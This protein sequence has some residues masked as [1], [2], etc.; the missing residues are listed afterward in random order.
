MVLFLKNGPNPASFCLFSSFSQHNDKYITKFDFECVDIL[1][2][3][4]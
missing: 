4:I 3:E 1:I 2:V